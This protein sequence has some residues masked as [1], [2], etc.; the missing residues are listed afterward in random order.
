MTVTP[1]RLLMKCFSQLQTAVKASFPRVLAL[2]GGLTA[3]REN[4]CRKELDRQ[5]SLESLEL[6]YGP[7][8]KSTRTVSLCLIESLEGVPSGTESLLTDQ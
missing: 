2:S 5:Q 6:G 7:L 4:W 1:L 8:A 3:T